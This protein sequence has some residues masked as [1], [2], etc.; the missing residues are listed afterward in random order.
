MGRGIAFTIVVATTTIVPTSSLAVL[1]QILRNKATIAFES[2]S[3]S[4]HESGGGA[5]SRR[6]AMSSSLAGIMVAAASSLTSG[7]AAVVAVSAGAALVG[8]PLPAS[9]AAS[10]GG[11]VSVPIS[12][13]WTAVDGLNSLDSK[14]QVVSFD[15]AAYQAMTDDP[16]R[17]PFFRKAIERRLAIHPESMTVLDLGTGPFALFALMAAEAGAGKVYAIEANPQA[18]ESARAYVQRAGF[19]D[20]VTILEGFS[21]QLELPTKADFCIA[22]IVGSIASEEGAYATVLDA[23]KRLMKDPTKDS[24]W[25]PTRIQTYAAPASYSLHMLF[26]PPEFDWAKLK[27]EPVRFNCRD[28]GLAL[29][30][31]PV[32]VEDVSFANI[33]SK[34]Q[35]DN[36]NNKKR[37]FTFT[38]DVERME[39]N[40]ES[41][42]DEFRRGNSS[43]MDSEL[44]ATRTAHSLSGIALWPRLVLDDTTIVDSRHFGDGSHQRSH[45][46]TVLPIMSD[47][48]IENLV[49]GEKVD[50]T[51]DFHLPVDI[52]K[53]PAYSIRGA[54]Q[55]NNIV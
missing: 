4:D 25:I 3:S 33:L 50:I 45:W 52:F 55:Y 29:L 23:H 54:L 27:G 31:D 37:D 40:K 16:A 35:Q 10:T 44:L 2:S 26:G 5:V 7:G 41:F 43:P 46:Q 47:R 15:T 42:Y 38:V 24:S 48:P 30:S 1:P 18:A 39:D 32:L 12:A 17:T 49:G 6:E 8:E 13:A 36:A 21:T 34:E 51:C 28:R 19:E 22:E 11:G 9:A 14:S 53:P 20:V